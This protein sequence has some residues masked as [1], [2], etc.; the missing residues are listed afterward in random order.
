M[1]RT[2]V[3]VACV[4]LTTLPALSAE[5][6]DLP[7]Q[8]AAAKMSVENIA[9]SVGNYP[10]ALTEIEKARQSLKKAEQVYDKGQ[11]WMGLGGL[12]PDAEQEVSHNLQMVDM[13]I[14]LAQ[15]KAAKGRTD[16]EAAALDKQL[17]V[18][19]ARVKLLEDIKADDDRLRQTAQKYDAAS[20]ELANLKADQGKLVSQLDQVTA[21]KK[22]LEGKVA[23]LTE[24]KAE[25]ATQLEA[26]KKIAQPA[27]VPQPLPSTPK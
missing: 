14:S 8:I 13:A 27:T 20:K 11:K 21:D 12:K 15:S 26:A 23:A 17:A 2:I 22:K 5:K 10:K 1:L 19:K 9:A 25:L 16:E 18:V 3:A 7:S 4:I 24:E 6:V